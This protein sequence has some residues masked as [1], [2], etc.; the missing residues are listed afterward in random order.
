M[1]FIRQIV[2][3]LVAGLLFFCLEVV[4]AVVLG[5]A[6]VRFHGLK[7]DFHLA[8]EG[9]I[10]FGLYLGG[11]IAVLAFIGTPPRRRPPF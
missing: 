4:I 5:Y 6:V 9:G 10:R 3:A 2:G 7:Y 1:T 8:L 11:V